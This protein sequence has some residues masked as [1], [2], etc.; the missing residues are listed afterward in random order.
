MEKDT[1]KY[2]H[3]TGISQEVKLEKS[4]QIEKNYKM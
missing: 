2:I 1:G 3:Y 4:Y